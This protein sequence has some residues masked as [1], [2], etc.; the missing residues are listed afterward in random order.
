MFIPTSYFLNVYSDCRSWFKQHFFKE[1]SPELLKETPV[2][3]PI[4]LSS[5]S[6]HFHAYEYY[7]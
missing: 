5:F 2:Y 7:L 6:Q 3:A 4:A 1:A